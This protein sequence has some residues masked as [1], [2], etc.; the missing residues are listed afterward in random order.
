MIQVHKNFLDKIVHQGI[1][2]EIKSDRFPY[3]QSG[4][5]QKNKNDFHFSHILF[6]NNQG[7]ISNSYKFFSPIF[8]KLDVK[9]MVRAKLNLNVKESFKRIIG[10]YHYDFSDENKVP[11][12]EIKVA[13]Y[14]FNTTNG[15]TLIKENN[16]EKKIECLENSLVTFP[17]TLEHTGTSHTDTNFRY[18]LNINYI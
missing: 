9:V 5:I 2:E 18:V 17:N 8:E 12:K 11:L 16:K 13:I 3:Y 14:Y 1:F 4:S 15:E 6:N 7:I 10:G